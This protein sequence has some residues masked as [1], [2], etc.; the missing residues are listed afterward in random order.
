MADKGA[1]RPATRQRKDGT[2]TGERPPQLRVDPQTVTA[3]LNR[4]DAEARPP[5]V[6]DLRQAERY[7][8]RTY[9]VI[10]LAR[11]DAAVGA[12]PVASR[13]VSRGGVAFLANQFIYHGTACRV[14]LVSPH[15]R[16]EVVTGRVVRCRYLIGSGS[17]YEVGVKFDRLVDVALLVPGA[18]RVNVL[19]LHEAA[20]T[21]QLIG[22]L[23][24]PLSADL[25][26]LSTD[27]EAVTTVLSRDFDL[28]LIDLESR[29]F[30]AFA[31]TQQLRGGGYVGPIVGLA[32]DAGVRLRARCADAGLTGYIPKPVTRESLRS[33]ISS[34]AGEPLLS[35]LA[36]DPELTPLIN[37]FVAGLRARVQQL[38]LAIEQQDLA[39]VGEVVR[40]LRV[41]GGSYGFQPI[42]DAAENLQG[43]I[44]RGEAPER[45]R[46]VLYE[47]MNLCLT[48]RPATAVPPTPTA[49]RRTSL[50][51]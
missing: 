48:A 45:I 3:A 9:S 14:T 26:C 36:G 34:L 31:V 18:R 17:L 2:V 47:L 41:E 32:I 38:V 49:Y 19:L 33:L 15:G 4:L 8:Y 20:T 28:V 12:Q 7:A 42:T 43:A 22:G 35:T 29:T 16:P 25:T 46:S 27:Q 39:V 11:G 5:A 40:A 37:Q 51:A 21:H 10:E 23:L 1:P 24:K 44:V 6:L 13:N 30:D 50:P